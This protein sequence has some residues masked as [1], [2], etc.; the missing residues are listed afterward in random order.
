MNRLTPRDRVETALRGGCAGRIA[1]TMYECMIPQTRAE[2]EMRNRGMCIVDRRAVFKTHCPNVKVTEER[3]REGGRDLLRVHYE[4]PVGTVR[5][6]LEPAGFTTWVHERMFRSPDDYKVIEFLIRDEVY[7]EDYAAYAE[8]ERTSGGDTILRA[9]IGLEPL[10]QLISG[11]MI[12]MET[13]CLEWMERRDELLRLYRALVEKRREVYELVAASPAL[14]ANYG[15]NVVPE[16]IGP[17]VFSEY[18]LPHYAEAAEVM[19]RHGKLIGC[20]F[21]ANCRILAEVIAGTDLDYIEAFTPSPDTDMG[22]AEARAA[23]PDKVLWINF[24]SS[25]HLLDDAEVEAI[26]FRLAGEAGDPRGFL[27]GITENIPL[28]RWQH[29]CPAIM[30]GLE[31]HARE[32]PNRY[33]AESC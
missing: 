24:P 23:W 20:H 12:G 6:L 8:A 10:Q 28:D 32:C 13:F 22:V 5:L 30:D 9:Q 33:S 3:I 27:V 1:F 4:T 18:Y 11:R 29:S 26:A 14:H 7:E 19:H 2:R 17:E 21:D 15:G 25:Q 31:R 16:I